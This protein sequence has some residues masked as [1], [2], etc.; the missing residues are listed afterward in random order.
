MDIK[1]HGH[2]QQQL[3]DLFCRYDPAKCHDV[4]SRKQLPLKLAFAITIHKSQGLTQDFIEVDCAGI[5]A[6]GQLAVAIGRARR[7][8]GL[9]V[10]N[11]NPARHIIP[12]HRDVLT[13]VQQ[14]CNDFD[15]AL[16]CCTYEII[17][18][19]QDKEPTEFDSLEQEEDIDDMQNL[20]ILQALESVNNDGES[21]ASIESSNTNDTTESPEEPSGI[22]VEDL[23]NSLRYK[24]PRTA[25][26]EEVNCCL[27]ELLER[28]C[29]RITRIISEVMQ[30]F[31]AL[32]I[33]NEVGKDSSHGNIRKFYTAYHQYV[34]DDYPTLL[35]K[36]FPRGIGHTKMQCLQMACIAMRKRFVIAKEVSNRG[37]KPTPVTHTAITTCGPGSGTLRYL[38]GCCRKN[39]LRLT[40]TSEAAS[41]ILLHL[42]HMRISMAEAIAGKYPNSIAEID[43]RQNG[44][45]G[46]TYVSDECF[47][48]F[49]AL[50][51]ERHDLHTASNAALHKAKAIEC[52]TNSLLQSKDL[53]SKF[54]NIFSD[55]PRKDDSIV[56]SLQKKC[57]E[58]YIRPCNNEFMKRLMMVYGN[59]RKLCHRSEVYRKAPQVTSTT[60]DDVTMTSEK[61][62]NTQGEDFSKTRKE[63]SWKGKRK[64]QRKRPGKRERSR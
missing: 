24:N 48:F 54:E 34:A 5:F 39:L 25:K 55:L 29:E 47:E 19:K 15:S 12:A 41:R 4:C 30:K 51:K 61:P 59:K 36:T 62:L 2:V 23:L 63:G 14:K 6:P 22:N 8:C 33:M 32:W 58:A 18:H 46:L 42:G 35:L 3:L 50:E 1:K 21:S 20:Q 53:K 40:K 31:Y 7:A 57:I 17:C 64:R 10:V 60:A 56:L 45:G 16:K 28:D 52:S 27:S 43:R 13:F 11:F 37:M 26:Q 9:H 38:A 49:S 44:S